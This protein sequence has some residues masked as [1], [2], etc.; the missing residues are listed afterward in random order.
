MAAAAAEWKEDNDLKEEL[1]LYV[2]QNLGR[3]EIA[4][5]VKRDYPC[6]PWSIPTL[7][8]RLRYF[9]INYIE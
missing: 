1:Q 4:D 8:C 3:A 7:D 2:S 9:G 5:Y 6:Y